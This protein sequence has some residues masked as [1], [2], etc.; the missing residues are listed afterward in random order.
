MTP[1]KTLMVIKEATVVFRNIS[2]K[3]TDDDM[4]RMNQT[5]LLILLILFKIPYDQVETTHNF[6]SL[7]LPSAKYI[8]KYGTA[9]QC[10]T[11]PKPYSPTIA[12]TMSDA[13][14]CK[15][16]ATYLSHK[17]DYL[18]Y[19]AAEM[20]IMRFLATNANET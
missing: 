3:I 7:I 20:E 11:R 1:E 8:A 6:S 17:E 2:T 4:L 10:P 9:F 16:E 14:R 5:L 12:A 19:E 13:E 15:A 18:L